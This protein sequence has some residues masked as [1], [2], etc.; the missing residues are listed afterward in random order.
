MD[1]N[2]FNNNYSLNSNE[3]LN[4]IFSNIV[5]NTSSFSINPITSTNT[6][7]IPR[8][9]DIIIMRDNPVDFDRLIAE[10]SLEETDFEFYSNRLKKREDN[11]YDNIFSVIK[12][13]LF[14]I[15]EEEH[16]NELDVN[17]IKNKY[18]FNDSM[19]SLSDFKKSVVMLHNKKIETEIIFSNNK[20]KYT[21]FTENILTLLK[22]IQEFK[23]DSDENLIILL[24]DKI[25]WFYTELNLLNLKNECES[26]HKEYIIIKK[27]L[28]EFAGFI[29]AVVC[30]ICLENQVTHFIDSCGHT[31]CMD[32]MDKSKGIRNCHFC[33]NRIVSF[34]RLYL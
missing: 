6:N 1:I 19:S 25:E 5:Q 11:I 27:L 10:R 16:V 4:G 18:L 12:N 15:N 32:C 8:N 21:K 26:L 33:R 17:E 24:T 14:I 7:N 31:M 20:E 23:N 22:T 3:S 34:K 29:P 9:E 30:Q 13:K 28:N 2:E